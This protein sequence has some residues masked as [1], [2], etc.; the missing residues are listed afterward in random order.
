MGMAGDAFVQHAHEPR[1]IG[2]PCAVG[3]GPLV[4][5]KRIGCPLGS[6]RPPSGRPVRAWACRASTVSLSS[7]SPRKR[8]QSEISSNSGPT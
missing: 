5:G 3:L 7:D 1:Q 6:A 8:R 4:N 2:Q